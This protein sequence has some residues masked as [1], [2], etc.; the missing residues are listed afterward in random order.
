MM[1][2]ESNSESRIRPVNGGAESRQPYSGVIAARPED[3]RPLRR[4]Y[5]DLRLGRRKGPDD[6]V[7]VD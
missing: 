6:I 2:R 7:V 5:D 3:I 4:D 1:S